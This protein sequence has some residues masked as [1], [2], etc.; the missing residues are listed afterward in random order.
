[1]LSTSDGTSGLDT[2][3]IIGGSVGRVML[4]LIILVLCIVIYSI[5]LSRRKKKSYKFSSKKLS[6]LSSD[7]TMT[8][9]PSHEKEEAQYDY[10]KHDKIFQCLSQ[11]DKEDTIKLDI[12]PSYEGFQE[13]E[14]TFYGGNNTTQPECNV[15]IQM[16]PSYEF[17]SRDI[18]EDQDGYVKTDQYHSHSREVAN[19]LE[20]ILPTTNGESSVVCTG[21]IDNLDTNPNPSYDSVSDGV[22]LEDNP[23]YNKIKFT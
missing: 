5:N 13:S 2:S 18:S 4:L 7:I 12:N 21:D 20:I 9:R 11:G 14:T 3:P 17:N 16:N 15:T 6:E 1:M 23:S 8:T 22:K 10:I 19:Y